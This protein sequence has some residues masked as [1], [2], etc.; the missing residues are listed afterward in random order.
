MLII[1][2][3]KSLIHCL[4]CIL[5]GFIVFSCTHDEMNHSPENDYAVKNNDSIKDAE[6]KVKKLSKTIQIEKNDTLE[7]RII[8]AGL[9]DIQEV[10]SSLMVDVK[11][12]SQ[13]NFMKIDLYGHLN[14]IYLQ[15]EVA[16]RLSL[17]QKALKEK[18]S[19]LSLLVYDGVRPLSVQKR[20]WKALDTIPFHERIK[21]VSNPKNGSIHNY[22]CA[23][24]LTIFDLESNEILDMGAG[25]DD[26][27]KIAYPR[28][29]QAYLESGE[30]TKEQY[31]NRVLLRSVM[32]K[33]GFWVIQ[34]EWWH[35]NAFT[36]EKAKELY[37]VVE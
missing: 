15:K 30:L 34:T 31:E 9:I 25:Y 12:S 35:F 8:E 1:N 13:D 2:N 27:R 18:D 26:L 24:D 36:R 6:L 11:Y 32:R 3:L 28:Y 23:V 37:K 14:K 5:V 22:G 20:M 7:Q 16:E 21:F 4:L 17:A 19:T 10:D 33:G 29:E